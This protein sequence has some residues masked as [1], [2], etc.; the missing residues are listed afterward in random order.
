MF[1]EFE[2]LAHEL[3]ETTPLTVSTLNNKYLELNHYYFGSNVH[4]DPEIATEWARIPH[5]YYNFYG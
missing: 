1:A 4:I 3:S 2:L 5:F